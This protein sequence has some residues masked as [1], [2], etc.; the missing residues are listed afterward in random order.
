MCIKIYSDE[1]EETADRLGKRI[2]ESVHEVSEQFVD[3]FLAIRE[4]Y[5]N[6]Q[7]VIKKMDDLVSEI[8]NTQYCFFEKNIFHEEWRV[9]KSFDYKI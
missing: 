5:P 6:D 1:W 2:R 4:K 7:N 9:R 8:F 3:D